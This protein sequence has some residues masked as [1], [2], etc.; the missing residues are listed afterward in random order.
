[1]VLN[2]F[3]F[4]TIFG[5]RN[6]ILV[7][8]TTFR[9]D[10]KLCCGLMRDK[11]ISFYHVLIFSLSCTQN[12]LQIK[13]WITGVV[14]SLFFTN[15]KDVG[16]HLYIGTRQRQPPS[17]KCF[18]RFPFLCRLFQFQFPKQANNKVQNRIISLHNTTGIALSLLIHSIIEF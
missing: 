1:M 11:N 5:G 8:Q 16:V 18:L 3:L 17:R 4:Y 14:V 12:S 6:A 9:C 2:N 7:F 10:K 15:Q 13:P